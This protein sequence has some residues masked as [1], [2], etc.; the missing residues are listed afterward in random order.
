MTNVGLSIR[1]SAARGAW[2]RSLAF[3]AAAC[4]A[5][6]TVEPACGGNDVC[7]E[8]RSILLG[9]QCKPKTSAPGGVSL[10]ARL[11]S[12]EA[13]HTG[14]QARCVAGC[15]VEFGPSCDDMTLNLDPNNSPHP[16]GFLG[17]YINCSHTDGGFER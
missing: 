17:C 14:M 8:Y 7:D 5:A 6:L 4:F 12:E 9:L 15:V 16:N 13:C 3:A 2:K 10:N 1:K 11:P